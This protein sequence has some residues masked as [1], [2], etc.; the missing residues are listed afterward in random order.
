MLVPGSD[1]GPQEPHVGGGEAEDETH[2]DGDDV[3]QLAASASTSVS[4]LWNPCSR[5]RK[6]QY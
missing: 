6:S 2:Y 3:A 5:A 1:L 4:V